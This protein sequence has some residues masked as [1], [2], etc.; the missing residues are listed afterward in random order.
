[1]GH[2][3]AGSG[4]NQSLRTPFG[5]KGISLGPRS[6]AWTPGLSQQS[7]PRQSQQLVPKIGPDYWFHNL[8]HEL[9]WS[10]VKV[11]PN[12]GEMKSQH[13]IKYNAVKFLKHYSLQN[14]FLCS[15]SFC[16]GSYSHALIKSPF[17]T[18]TQQIYE[19]ADI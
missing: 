18:Y 13:I 16:Q 3:Q 1:M 15:S 19:V 17:C 11:L 8:D 6:K 5:L 2:A 4:N 12:V 10:V 9:W 14:I 7:L